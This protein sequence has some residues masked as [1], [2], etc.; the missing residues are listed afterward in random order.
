MADELPVPLEG[1]NYHTQQVSFIRYNLDHGQK[2]LK[3][4]LGVLPRG[5]I[6]TAMKVYIETGFTGAKL[7]IGKTFG[8]QDF[9]EKDISNKGTQ[10][11]ALT[12]DKVFV[13]DDAELHL[14]ATRDKAS[15]VGKAVIY[16]QFV[17]NR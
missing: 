9:G 2:D 10:D 8:G 12:G 1:R 4:K 5:A 3:I 16:V 17:A 11:Y 6:I 7:S 13:G 15:D 14:Y